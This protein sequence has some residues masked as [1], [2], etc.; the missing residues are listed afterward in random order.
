MGQP[1]VAPKRASVDDWVT[2]LLELDAARS[3]MNVERFRMHGPSSRTSVYRHGVMDWVP[4]PQDQKKLLGT[5]VLWIV[6]FL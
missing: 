4:D 6:I 5:V 2:A 1:G 3:S